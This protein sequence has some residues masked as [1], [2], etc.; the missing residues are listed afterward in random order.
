MPISGAKSPKL[1]PTSLLGTGDSPAVPPCAA[2]IRFF[3]QRVAHELASASNAYRLLR[4]V[5]TRMTLCL[6]ALM[7]RFLAQ[8]GWAYTALSTAQENSFPNV[9]VFMTAAVRAYSLGLVP[10]REGL[11]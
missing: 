9:E 5:A 7:V 3:C 8:R 4:S 2:S 6:A 11:L 10:S 1:T